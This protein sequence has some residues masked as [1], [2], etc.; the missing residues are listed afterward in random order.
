MLEKECKEGVKVYW[1]GS[2]SVS[3]DTGTIVKYNGNIFHDC[4]GDSVWVQWDSDG[5]VL[6]VPYNE[7]EVINNAVI[8]ELTEEKAVMF[9]LSKGYTV[10]KGV[11]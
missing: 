10:S 8:K 4:F 11:K 1:G 6:Y 7:L 9:L 5:D 2:K 3:A